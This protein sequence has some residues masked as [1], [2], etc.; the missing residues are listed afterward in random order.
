MTRTLTRM[1]I[2]LFFV[3]DVLKL[4]CILGVSGYIEAVYDPKIFSNSNSY[5]DIIDQNIAQTF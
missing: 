4:S 5:Y 2:F 1:L 3:V